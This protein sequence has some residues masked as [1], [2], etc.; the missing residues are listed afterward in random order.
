MSRNW[1]AILG[2][3]LVKIVL[4]T[5]TISALALDK[6]LPYRIGPDQYNQYVWAVRF[7]TAAFF[8]ALVTTIFSVVCRQGSLFMLGFLSLVS[9]MLF[10]GGVR[11]G[12]NPEAWCYNNLG[13][14]DAA[15]QRLALTN[16]A[17]VSAG[18]ISKYIED[19]LDSLQCA[20]HGSYIIGPVG[21]EPR[22]T[23]HGS[24]SEMEA[25]WRKEMNQLKH[26]NPMPTNHQKSKP[27]SWFTDSDRGEG[28]FAPME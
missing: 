10:M 26:D 16:G 22:C 23:I 19:G 17:P 13:K 27:G 25:R 1:D 20:E 4:L 24:V 2:K 9:L 28:Q 12:P 6:T 15:K 7:A 21:T 5:I 18:Q 14:I 3:R 11:S 8:V